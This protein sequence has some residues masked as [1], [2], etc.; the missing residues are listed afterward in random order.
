VETLFQTKKAEKKILLSTRVDD[1]LPDVLVGD[2][3]RLT[4]VLVNLIDNAIK[5]TDIGEVLIDMRNEGIDGKTVKVGFDVKDTGIGIPKEKLDRIFDRFQQADDS[6]TREYGGSGLGLSIVKELVELQKGQITATSEPNKGTTFH[7]SIPYDISK[8]QFQI[9]KEIIQ[10]REQGPRIQDSKILIVED[11]KVNLMLIEH[12]FRIWNIDFDIANNGFEA[13]EKLKRDEFDL[14][15]MDIQMPQLDGYAAAHRIRNDLKLNTPIIA[16]TAHAMSG[17]RERCL[18]YGM[19][20]YISKPIREEQLK[21]LIAQ[22]LPLKISPAEIVEHPKWNR[23]HYKFI[24][25]DYMLEVSAGNK[26]YEKDVTK[27]FIEAVP[28]ELR[29]MENATLHHDKDSLRRI[30][31]NLRTTISVMGLN[32]KLEPYLDAIEFHEG[33]NNLKENVESINRICEKALGEAKDFLTSLE[34]LPL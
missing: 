28:R 18:S 24:N 20:E 13:I 2:A 9:D 25:L 33:E 11:N 31:H 32:E 30:A 10:P 23:Q 15:L 26:E 21:K 5:F 17:E 1:S 22:F 29:A 27:Q 7:L 19:N 14:I 12:L 4:Q 8:D 3:V 34:A 6:V 16:M